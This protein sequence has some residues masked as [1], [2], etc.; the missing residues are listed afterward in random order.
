MRSKGAPGG[1]ARA[2]RVPESRIRLLLWPSLSALCTYEAELVDAVQF[3]CG[4]AAEAGASLRGI[5]HESCGKGREKV[6]AASAP[7][8][9]GGH[10]AALQRPATPGGRVGCWL[11]PRTLSS[12]PV[13]GRPGNAALPEPATMITF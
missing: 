12:E 8:Q 7:G 2:I 9:A 11:I 6:L 5:G 4:G 13:L 1:P 10:T 3:C